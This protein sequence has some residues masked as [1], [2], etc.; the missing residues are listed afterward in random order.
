MR[1]ESLIGELP[2]APW[3]ELEIRPE[4]AIEMIVVHWDGGS[5]PFRA[6]YDPIAY[7]RQ[8]ARVH[9]ETD[10]LHLEPG[11]QGGYGLMYHE[12]IARDGRVFLTR[13]ASHVVWAARGANRIGYM[14]CVD[15]CESSPPTTHQL[16]S[17]EVRI[18][19]LCESFNLN[20]GAVWGHGE[21]RHL[22]NATECPGSDLL[23]WVIAQRKKG[24]EGA[25]DF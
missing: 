6:D 7:Y 4:N 19:A 16:E 8:E 5:K 24:L 22:G 10:W 25:G 3:N 23:A 12:K 9:I 11:V 21:L 20:S 1:V 14:L 2:V 18:S 17:L 15:A 13:P